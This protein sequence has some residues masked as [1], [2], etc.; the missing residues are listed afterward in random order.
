MTSVF[1]KY[2]KIFEKDKTYYNL[3]NKEKKKFRKSIEKS[4]NDSI[5][6]YKENPEYV[7]MLK[8]I[9]PEKKKKS[10]TSK[11]ILHFIMIIILILI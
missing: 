2:Q 11:F 7:N 4:Y 6:K 10:L 1:K 9:K 5:Y 8:N 3:T